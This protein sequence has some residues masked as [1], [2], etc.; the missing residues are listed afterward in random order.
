VRAE[1]KRE[2]K[3]AGEMAGRMAGGIVELAQWERGPAK[4]L[5]AGGKLK[6]DAKMAGKTAVG[7]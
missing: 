7:W 6:R 3:M 1:A 4:G 5:I 2:A